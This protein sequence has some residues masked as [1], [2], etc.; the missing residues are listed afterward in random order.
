MFQA[1]TASSRVQAQNPII[2]KGIE[3]MSLMVNVHD[4]VHAENE[5]TSKV[6]FY[7]FCPK[8]PTFVSKDTGIE[9]G[10]DCICDA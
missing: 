5:M 2:T 6:S 3:V 4:S 10:K 1:P 9:Q 8:T 7:V